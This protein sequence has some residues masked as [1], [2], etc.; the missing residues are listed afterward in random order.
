[1][2][3]QNNEIGGYFEL[4]LSSRKKEKYPDA[5]K[6]QSARAAFSS[7]VE[8]FSASTFW[9]PYY[10]CNSMLYPLQK[11][12]IKVKFYSIDID[13]MP[14]E[15]IELKKD[16]IILYVNYFG[17]CKKNQ[18]EFIK[19]FK[20]NQIIFDHSHSFYQKPSDVLA[21]LYSPRKFFGLP[22]G[23][24]LLTSLPIQP[25]E[26]EDFESIKRMQHLLIRLGFNAEKGY[27]DYIKSENSLS[28]PSPMK[29]SKITNN[30]YK[31]INFEAARRKRNKNFHLIHSFLKNSNELVINS[32][33][34]NGPLA[35]PYLKKNNEEIRKKL[36][37]NKIF[38]PTYWNDCLERVKKIDV[39]FYLTRN[40][41]PIPCDQ[42]ISKKDIETI[43]DVI[44]G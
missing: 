33:Y 34:I 40:L 38:T 13:L 9:M 21:T 29:M 1:M 36:L 27:Q 6:Y 26:E 43:L 31:S 4:E 19:K 7:V 11:K 39:E 8:N 12:N 15:N 17:I 35:Y 28:N 24:L 32:N 41:I 30:I 2:L 16:D 18:L 5:I 37:K 14:K 25:P 44:Q 42:R 23:G 20:K 22:D 10:I 3:L